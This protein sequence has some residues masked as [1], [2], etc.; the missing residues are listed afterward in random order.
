MDF[1]FARAA[2][3][4]TLFG[5]ERA[6]GTSISLHHLRHSLRVSFWRDHHTLPTCTLIFQSLSLKLHRLRYPDL[7]KPNHTGLTGGAYGRQQSSDAVSK[8]KLSRQTTRSTRK[9]QRDQIRPSWGCSTFLIPPSSYNYSDSEEYTSGAECPSGSS[10]SQSSLSPVS[11]FSVRQSSPPI[12]PSTDPNSSSIRRPL[13]PSRQPTSVNTQPRSKRQPPHA[14][15]RWREQ[16]L[17]RHHFQPTPRRLR[18]D[19]FP[20]H[21]QCCGG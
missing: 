13:L 12:Q 7:S 3:S 19:L 10:S 18:H 15:R 21:R 4:E 14:D 8:G 20:L 11:P 16:F 1:H 6:R 9:N 5:A 17:L 2:A